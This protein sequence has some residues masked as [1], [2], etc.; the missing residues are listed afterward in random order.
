MFPLLKMA[1]SLKTWKV[2]YCSGNFEQCAR[3]KKLSL[4]QTVAPDLMPNGVLLSER[5]SRK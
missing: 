4:G 1:S 5:A 3:Y 2:R